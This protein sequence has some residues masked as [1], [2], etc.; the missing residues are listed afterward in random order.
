MGHTSGKS[1]ASRDATP[2]EC[3]TAMKSKRVVLQAT[4]TDYVENNYEK[5][6]AG[7][8][9]TEADGRLSVN[10]SAQV[11][12]YSAYW[13]GRWKSEWTI[14]FD[15][16][17]ATVEGT[18]CVMAHYYEKGT[19]RCTTSRMSRV[20]ISRRRLTKTLQRTL[21][22]ISREHKTRFKTST[23]GCTRQ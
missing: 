10:I 7:G 3:P 19:C 6:G 1:G 18:I 12:K 8:V 21:S 17:K 4:L 20:P 16:A 23:R 9:V 13:S 22:R 5:S 14:Q 2:E 11:I 15:G